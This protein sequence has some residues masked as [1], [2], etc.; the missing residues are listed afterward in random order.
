LCIFGLSCCCIIDIEEK[1]PS[2]EKEEEERIIFE[3]EMLDTEINPSEMKP[4]ELLI[5]RKVFTSS[6]DDLPKR[7]IIRLERYRPAAPPLTTIYSN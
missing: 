7:E 1:Y 5:V 6:D 3:N 2:K 4:G